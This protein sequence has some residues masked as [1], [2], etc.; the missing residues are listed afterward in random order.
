MATH[1]RLSE[2]SC[3]EDGAAY[4]ER[5]D[6]YF[7]AN[8]VTDAAKK[9]VNLLSVVGDKTYQLIRNLVALKKPT[10]K[11]YRDLVELLTTHLEPKLS[12]GLNLIAASVEKGKQQHNSLQNLETLHVI[13]SM[14]KASILSKLLS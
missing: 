7:L 12:K 13:A 8:D 9:R 11:S 4:V 10:D 3:T 1:R 14:V 2:Y 6:Q 5:M